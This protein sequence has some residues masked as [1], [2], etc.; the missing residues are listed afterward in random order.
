MDFPPFLMPTWSGQHRVI[1]LLSHRNP[2]KP[3]GFTWISAPQWGKA[4]LILAALKQCCACVTVLL[5]AALKWL[6][7]VP[8]ELGFLAVTCRWWRYVFVRTE[9]RILKKSQVK[10]L[11]F[12]SRSCLQL[13]LCELRPSLTEKLT[14]QEQERDIFFIFFFLGLWF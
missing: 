4:T 11:T 10:T 8:Q 3:L 12:K 7:M 13:Q 1:A 6:A 9:F 2:E 14:W 5:T